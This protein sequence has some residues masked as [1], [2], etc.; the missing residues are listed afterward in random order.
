MTHDP[1]TLDPEGAA[2]VRAR[3][4]RPR[5]VRSAW[6]D[7]GGEWEFASE[8]NPTSQLPMLV[9]GAPPLPLSQ[10]IVVPYP[11]E[12]PMSTV[13]E[14]APHD[15]VWY[16]RTLEPSDIDAAGG[17]A[18]GRRLLLHFG[19]V[20]YRARVWVDGQLAA[21]HEGG[22]TPFAVDITDHVHV[23]GTT[24]IIVSA[25][26]D[27]TDLEQPRGKQD[28]QTHPHVI[29]Y[30]RTT[31][32]WQPVWLESTPARWISDLRL[33]ADVHAASLTTTIELSGGPRSDGEL[34]VV[35]R[36]GDALLGSVRTS[37]DARATSATVSCPVPVLRNGQEIENWLW[38]PEHP[39]LFD[40]DVTFT[41]ALGRSDTVRSYTGFRS[42]G[43]ESGRILLNDRPITVCAVLEQGFW[44]ESHLAAPDAAALRREVQLIRALGFT[45]ARIHEKVEDPR[46]LYWADVLGLMIWSEMP[47]AYEYSP[48]A[49]ER[50]TNE[51]LAVLR[52]DRS[53]P[54]IV[55]WVP[56]NESWGVQHVAHD[57]AQADFVEGMYR[58][59]RAVDSTRLVIS[60]DGWEHATSDLL[61]VHDYT[62]DPESFAARYADRQ[63]MVA[64]IDGVGP[65]GRRMVLPGHPETTTAPVVVS[66]FGGITYAPE[67]DDPDV[68]GYATVA[69]ADE[70]ERLLRALISAL[71][72][73]PVLAGYC[74]TQLTDT[75]QE[76]NGLVTAD[77]EPKLPIAT[78]RSIVTGE[79]PQ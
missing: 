18:D 30:H 78:L 20:D 47:S 24:S 7:L 6:H 46:F 37:I 16:R 53:H 63:S 10:R 70:F 42:I 61:T 44:P 71:Q 27:A 67:S 39:R 77:R 5:L 76:A 33:D 52:R 2:D 35:I 22:H 32:I 45:T 62:V 19:A 34:S 40:V 51:W 26:D 41:D 21:Q 54:C 29:W 11:P 69:T 79:A 12:S 28:W 1:T 74:Y 38:S 66:E 48:R 65:A 64:A 57:R 59:T 9:D 68:W 72:S 15:R 14:T 17:L 25:D 49:I 36:D 3:H 43:V 58:L 75:M 73:S 8:S 50:T 23:E 4:P 56:L 60:N 55:A 13:H 31:G